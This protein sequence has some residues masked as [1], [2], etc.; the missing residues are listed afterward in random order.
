MKLN[1]CHVMMTW[2]VRDHNNSTFNG[3]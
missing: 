3:D 1:R 2:Q